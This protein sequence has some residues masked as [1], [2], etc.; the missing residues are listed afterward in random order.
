VFC[1]I[2]LIA[3]FYAVIYNVCCRWECTGAWNQLFSLT[4]TGL[5]LASMPKSLRRIRSVEHGSMQELCLQVA[6]SKDLQKVVV[7]VDCFPRI[8]RTFELLHAQRVYRNQ[9][10]SN[11]STDAANNNN[12]TIPESLSPSDAYLRIFFDIVF[13]D[14]PIAQKYK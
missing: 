13:A 7:L 11:H 1:K 8:Q 14:G 2:C 9:I 12:I 4:Q 3:L 6:T 5:L 10:I